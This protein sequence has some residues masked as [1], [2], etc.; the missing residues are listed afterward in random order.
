MR[1]TS[2]VLSSYALVLLAGCSG[3]G[4]GTPAPTYSV[5]GSVSTGG[6]ANTGGAA[7][8]GGSRN[9]GG[10]AASTGGAA[11]GGKS[12]SSNTAATGG[13]YVI[14][15]PTGGGNSVDLGTGG[16]NSTTGGS[17]TT[18]TG[19]RSGVGGNPSTGGTRTNTGGTPST[20]TGGTAMT[21][22]NSGTATGGTTP[23]GG[24]VSACAY[25]PVP[26]SANTANFSPST[27]YA[28]W[29][30]KFYTDCGN[31]SARIANGQGSN[32]TVSEGMG[33]GML[34]AVGNADKTA[35]DALWAYY[36][37]HV[38]V[39]G[40]MNWSVNGCTA[41][42]PGSN[43]NF[44]ATD[45]DEDVAMALVQAD[46]KWGSYA[47]D[48]KSLIGLIKK[49]ETSQTTTPTYLRPGDAANNGGKGE[50]IV[51]PSYFAPGY[52]RVWATYTADTSWNKLATDSYTML[53]AF[54][55]LSIKDP[56]G[57]PYTGALVPDWGNSAGQNPYGGT[58][59]YDAC[60]TPWRVAVDYAWFCT[61]ESKTF[62][63]NVSTFVDTTKSGLTSY[64]SSLASN[65]A[66]NSAFIGP[67]ALTGMA[68]S[69][70]KAD[71]YL[72]AWLSAQM[73]DTPYFQGSLRGLYLLLANLQFPSGI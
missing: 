1:V 35:F 41:Q 57:G 43:D 24:S 70:S 50:G 31:G 21:G 55:T 36:K 32:N 34:L 60:R 47:T 10:T 38:D 51:N 13:S 52:W 28:S 67:F 11:T 15:H 3:G 69:Q 71:T 45:G 7:S 49:F 25:K 65:G 56:T 54:Q 22:G 44:A 9:V 14:D 19:G 30:T 58:Y 2:L 16:G 72:N 68:V 62:L 33:Y 63:Q 12:N 66:G 26:S 5:G 40:L 20:T 42:T 4:G 27:W 59:Y 46:G 53:A 61:A 8:T 39:N 18:A 37:S 48:A 64:A 17:M 6:N 73:D 29:K 23:A